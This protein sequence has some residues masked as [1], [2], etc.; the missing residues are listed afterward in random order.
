MATA[1][2]SGR[3]REV[4]PALSHMLGYAAEDLTGL[5]YLDI[6]HPDDRKECARRGRA[7]TAGAIP[8]F[9]LEERFVRK[10]GEPIWV[11]IN[12]SPLR[13]R[14]WLPC[15]SRGGDAGPP[16]E[17][18]SASRFGRVAPSVIARRH[19]QIRRTRFTL[20][21]PNGSALAWTLRRWHG[22]S[23]PRFAMT[24]FTSSRIPRCVALSKNAFRR[25]SPRSTGQRLLRCKIACV[26]ARNNRSGQKF[27][28]GSR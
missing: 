2:L 12:V 19:P 7:A 16:A 18:V 8:H 22:E 26:C 14:A 23:W 20:D 28:G 25:S 5:S 1:D 15:T 9:Q 24:N 3:F 10:S 13:G 21:L 6:V 27:T 4:N 11:R 17:P